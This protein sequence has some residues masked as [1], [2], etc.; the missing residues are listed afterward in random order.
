MKFLSI[1]ASL[2]IF[3][4]VQSQN[5]SVENLPEN[6]KNGSDA[7]VR[8]SE[9]EFEILSIDKAKYRTKAVITI[10][11]K[12]GNHN[13]AIGVFYDKLIS[14]N[15]FSAFKYDASGKRIFKAK[16]SDFVDQAITTGVNFYDDNRIIGIDMRQDEFPY[17]IE[18]EYELTFKYLYFIPK[19]YFHSGISEAVEFS[20]YSIISPEDLKPRQQSVNTDNPEESYEE[21]KLIWEWE[22]SNLK[23]I[24]PEP[25]GLSFK[26]LAPHVIVSPSKFE[27]D[28]YRGD[29]STWDGFAKWQN[30]LNEGRSEIPQETA[31]YIKKAT[32]NLSD[33]EKVKVIYE[34]LQSK[35]RYVS[36]QLGIGGFQPFP[37][38]FVDD[39]GYGDC[40]AL[41]FYTKSLLQEVGIES[42]YTLVYGGD[43]P[44]IINKDFPSPAYFNHVI[45]NVPLAE[46]TIW[47]EC[48]SQTNPFGYLGSFTGNRDA[49]VI[50]NEGG[51]IVRTPKYDLK[52][53]QRISNVE[54]KINE[55][56][57]A[58]LKIKNQYKGLEYEYGNLNFYVNYGKDRQKK[59]IQNSID[60]PSFSIDYFEFIH[61][62]DIPSIEL[63]TSLSA[64]KLVSKSGTRYFLQPNIINKNKWIPNKNNNRTQ[65][66]IED[67]AYWEIDTVIYEL[68]EQHTVEAFFDPIEISSEFGEYYAEIKKGDDG[69]IIYL[70]TYKQFDGVFPNTSYENYINFHKQIVRA[71]KKRISFKKK[72]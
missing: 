19:W 1:I 30:I 26:E 45:L 68:P 34:Y 8:F 22:R 42:D 63:K 25:Y 39:V 16:N 38:K 59:W 18:Y 58:S 14:V 7:V 28:G 57:N 24:N 56:G 11:N 29:L 72:T 44:P 64:N 69:K 62:K 55:L 9:G 10:L 27:F 23:A 6:L 5:Y 4:L 33:E 48:T 21:G 17:S 2:L 51:S 32:H 3:H 53:N 60:I 43:N 20:R 71:D 54:V 67:H 15:N 70:R 37:A 50:S 13:A 66:I 46:D 12:D 52:E 65:D 41:S 36:I 47:L 35:T 61:N 31:D 49:L 40:K